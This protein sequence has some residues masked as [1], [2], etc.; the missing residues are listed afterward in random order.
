M[1]DVSEFIRRLAARYGIGV[2]ARARAPVLLLIA[3][4]LFLFDLVVPDLVPF[5]DEILL[6]VATILLARW[7][8]RER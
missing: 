5:V 8:I 7:R 4:G 2:L 1:R 6:G 3:A